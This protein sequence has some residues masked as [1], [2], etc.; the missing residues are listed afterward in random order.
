MINII[1]MKQFF[2]KIGSVFFDLFI[3]SN[4]WMHFLVGGVITVFMMSLTVI[5]TPYNPIPLQ[6]V[7][8]GLFSNLIAMCA[9][10]YKDLA[11]GGIFDWKDMF[12]GI[13]PAILIDILVIILLMFK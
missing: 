6:A 10:E 3:D 5:W 4:R 9:V 8:V 1:N 7:S 2:K 11:K 12:A 13:T